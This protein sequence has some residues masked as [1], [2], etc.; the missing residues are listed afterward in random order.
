[1][2]TRIERA[3]ETSCTYDS[4]EA[5]RAESRRQEQKIFGWAQNKFYEV[6]PGGRAIDWTGFAAEYREDL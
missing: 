2:S 5:V 1:V 6:W 4:L 3:S